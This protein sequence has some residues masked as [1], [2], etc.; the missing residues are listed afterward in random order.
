MHCCIWLTRMHPDVP[1]EWQQLPIR[2]GWNRWMKD[3]HPPPPE[4]CR[5]NIMT[6]ILQSLA[7][8]C[9]SPILRS[10]RVER[11]RR[12]SKCKRIVLILNSADTFSSSFLLLLICLMSGKRFT[13]EIIR[14]PLSSS[15]AQQMLTHQLVQ[16]PAKMTSLKRRQLNSK[17]L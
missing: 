5:N 14:S 4:V 16:F 10:E 11:V 12:E 1:K 2:T 15:S 9:G 8:P 6:P 17:L 7:L 3:E 13:E